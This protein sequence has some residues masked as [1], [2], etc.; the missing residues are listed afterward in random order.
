MKRLALLFLF[1]FLLAF[2]MSGFATPLIPT[3]V[4]QQAENKVEAQFSTSWIYDSPEDI[5]TNGEVIGRNE[6]HADIG[7]EVP[8]TGLALT[9]ASATH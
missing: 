2:A 8:L 1:V 3:A 5:F 9:L 4:A 7:S 6:W